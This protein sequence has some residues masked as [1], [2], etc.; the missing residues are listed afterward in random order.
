MPEN[1]L[2]LLKLGGSPYEIGYGHGKEGEDGIRR[3]LETIIRHGR[4]LVP[5]LTRDKALRQAT[6]YVPFIEAYAPHLAEEIKGIADGAKISLNEAYLLQARAELT[7][8]TIEKEECGGGC[9][10]FALSKTR[11]EDGEVWMGQN[12]D[13]SPIYGDAG[14]MFHITPEK[15]PAILCYSQI[16]SLA[17]AGINSAGLGWA[18]NALFSSGW[19]PGVPRPVLYRL[20]LESGSVAEAIRV[21]TEAHRASSCNYLLGHKDGE[22]RDLETTPDRFGVI[23]PEDGVLVHANHYAHPGMV[24]FEKRPG[25]KLENSRFREDRFRGLV[26]NHHGR[27]SEET[28]KGF[29]TD[30]VRYPQAVCAHAEGNPWNIATIASFIAEPARGLMHVA[31]GQGCS[32]RY[33]T[34]SL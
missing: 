28:I 9:T 12:V 17:H 21:V 10:S 6:H 19:R 4:E 32:N 33:V 7:Q 20:V 29:L 31:S 1:D 24:P 34:Y 25:E 18:A 5:D 27:L 14:V 11:T 23:D 26:S 13:L 15:G 16:G 8:L 3:F 22:I 30:H 2:R